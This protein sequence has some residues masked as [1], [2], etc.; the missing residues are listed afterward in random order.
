[1]KDEARPKRASV[2]LQLSDLPA[3][4][5]LIAKGAFALVT[6]ASTSDP[7]RKLFVLRGDRETATHLLDQHA[8]GSVTVDLDAYLAAQKYLRDRLFRL[9]RVGR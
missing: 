1:M 4:A 5:L 9:D 6:I 8:A 3:A 7:R 2:E